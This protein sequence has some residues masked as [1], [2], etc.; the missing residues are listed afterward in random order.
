[1]KKGL[2]Y[3]RAGRFLPPC[4]GIIL[5]LASTASFAADSDNDG[6]PDATDNCTLHANASQLDA[7]GDG[8]GN[9]CDPDFNNNG[10]VDSQDGALFKAAFGSTQFP[11]RD[12]NGNGIVDSQDGAI[13]KGWFGKAPGPYAAALG[14][15][16]RPVNTTCIAPPRPT[17]SGS[18]ATL[19]AYPTAPA[20]NGPVKI[21]QAPNDPSRW[22]VLEKQGYVKVFPVSNP[23]AT[24][25]Y[26]N[27]ANLVNDSSG[28]SGLLGMAFHPNFPGTPEVYVSYIGVPG[29]PFVSKLS[30]FI[31]DNP[32]APVN[33]VEQVLMTINK[34]TGFH[35]GGDIAFGNDGFLY[36]A[37]GD[38][39][40]T[41]DP[42]NPGQDTTTLLGT[43]LR[44]NVLGVAWPSPRYTIPSTNP[45]AANPVCGPNSNALPC[46]EIY[47]W[48]FRNP[49]RWTFDRPTGQIWLGDVGQDAREEINLVSLG[50]NYGWR[51]REGTLPFD[52]SGCP[53]GGF[54]E[55]VIDYG[56]S[57]GSSV[58]GGFAYRGTALPNL[59]GRYVFGDF[60]EGSIWALQPNGQGG[61]TK[62]TIANT[63]FL[64]SAFGIGTDNEL[65]V[66]DFN[67]GRIHRLVPG[68]APVPDT[69]PT[70]LTDT[71]CV[72]PANPT[73]PATGVVPYGVNATF[74]SDGAT[75]TRYLAI[76][77][78]A[79]VNIEAINGSAGGDWTLPNGSVIVKNFALNGLPVETRLLMRHPDGIWAGYTYEWNAAGTHAT[80]VIGGKSRSVNGQM[81]IYP[82][83]NDCMRCH[84]PTAGFALGAETAQ[85]NGHFIYPGTNRTSNQ[86]AT[87]AAIG[88]FSAPLPGAPATLPALAD[89]TDTSQPLA[90]RARAWLHTNC[91][92]CH[93]PGGP[94]PSNM[95]LRHSTALAA[96]N[97]CNVVPQAGDL[98]ISDARLIA[99]GNAAR[100]VVIARVNRRDAQGMPPLGST[101]VD[102]AAVSLLTAWVNGLGGC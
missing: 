84:T 54:V 96:T 69:I 71:G 9:R 37:V 44:I 97:I 30:R 6:I 70:N 101:L 41:Y 61:Y 19:N 86:L 64:I 81:W 10:I 73:Q 12:L 46:P 95:D 62:Q 34:P 60:V 47:A 7:N 89:P 25:T 51:C 72:N 100:S 52:M 5:A 21:L 24:S 26:L 14:L 28:E 42:L 48:G 66:V 83:E 79:T 75:K 76:P 38:G 11:D 88:M 4:L 49:W 17:G 1:M 43:M 16:A 94:T 57:D 50:G 87:L 85:A 53:T 3:V 35:H 74:W 59:V 18:I 99:P 91:A 98:G 45:F 8:I 31:L 93:Q 82:S 55:P 32:V 77:N 80:R 65:Y 20:F 33:V 67:G 13:S 15:D 39:G 2:A 58:T 29:G 102:F 36:L 63:N 92:N 23:A 27:I 68:G 22:F 90:N 78:G 56:R 40:D